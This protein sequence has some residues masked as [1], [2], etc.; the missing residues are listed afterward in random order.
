MIQYCFPIQ[1]LV[2]ACRQDPFRQRLLFVIIS[3]LTIR[4]YKA[5]LVNPAL[6]AYG[7]ITLT[8]YGSITLDLI[9][10]LRLGYGMP[11]RK[12][13]LFATGT[14]IFANNMAS[15][16]NVTNERMHC[17]KHKLMM[18][19][20]ET[21]VA[22]DRASVEFAERSTAVGATNDSR[23]LIDYLHQ[24]VGDATGAGLATVNMAQSVMSWNR[25]DLVLDTDESWFLN[26]INKNGDPTGDAGLLIFY[27]T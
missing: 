25:G 7:S 26:G 14:T 27:E 9:N 16:T 11:L 20:V 22:L 1:W 5:C 8:A 3:T 23:A 17:R 18:Q 15:F 24:L 10:S 19:I 13:L 4:P 6:T 2:L 12:V 21:V